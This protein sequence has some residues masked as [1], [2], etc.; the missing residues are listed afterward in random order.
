[1]LPFA[2]IQNLMKNRISFHV[3]CMS[4]PG[5]MPKDEKRAITKELDNIGYSNFF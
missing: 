5:L 3:A 4:D 1:M 2:A